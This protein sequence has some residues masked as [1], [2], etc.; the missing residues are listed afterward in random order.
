MSVDAA[1]ESLRPPVFF[2]AKP[3]LKAHATR[4]NAQTCAT[5]LARLQMLELDSKRHG[6]VSLT[7]VAHGLMEIAHLA[8][9]KR[10]A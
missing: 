5:A 6:D 2:K 8:S 9:T 4:W 7:R 10:A 1:I 3:L